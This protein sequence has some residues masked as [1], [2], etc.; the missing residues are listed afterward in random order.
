[1]LPFVAVEFQ[2]ALNIVF[3]FEGMLHILK[4]ALLIRLG[5]VRKLIIVI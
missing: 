2:P 3:C 1:M 5:P 4:H